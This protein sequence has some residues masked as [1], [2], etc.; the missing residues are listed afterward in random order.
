M[1]GGGVTI[2][3]GTAF[4][5]DG[6]EILLRHNNFNRPEGTS[7]ECSGDASIS[8]KSVKVEGNCYTSQLSVTPNAGLNNRTVCCVNNSMTTIGT[9]TIFLTTGILLLISSYSS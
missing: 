3:T 1:D 8:A 5:C 2:W 6:N 4:S 9:S 7:G